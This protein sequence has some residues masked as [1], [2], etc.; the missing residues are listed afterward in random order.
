MQEHVTA[1]FLYKL[2]FV[3]AETDG[4]DKCGN[5]SLEM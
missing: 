2:M 3:P 1:M 4:D 5:Y